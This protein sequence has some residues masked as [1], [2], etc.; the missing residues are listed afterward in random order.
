[1]STLILNFSANVE[2]YQGST[3]DGS[4]GRTR[5][6]G[7]YVIVQTSAASARATVVC[8]SIRWKMCVVCIEASTR[9]SA[10]CISGLGFS[11]QPVCQ[12][13]V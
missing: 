3:P 9:S 6:S 12:C 8:A 13:G 7:K 4:A 10:G 5:A 2:E 1:M 11:M